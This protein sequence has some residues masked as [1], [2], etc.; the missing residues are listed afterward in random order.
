[1]KPGIMTFTVAAVVAAF[2]LAASAHA[3]LTVTKVEG[4][5]SASASYQNGTPD[6]KS[7]SLTSAGSFDKTVNA[8]STGIDSVFHVPGTASASASL[9]S[10]EEDIAA[11]LR[12]AQPEVPQHFEP[13]QGV[14]DVVLVRVGELSLGDPAKPRPKIGIFDAS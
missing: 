13:V 4:G 7:E 9:I 2:V 1:M 12:R 6:S 8:S 3:Q 5:I 11:L 14:L 10:R